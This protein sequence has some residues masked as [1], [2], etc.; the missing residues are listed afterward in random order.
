METLDE[1]STT[2]KPEVSPR[3]F[4]LKLPNPWL[5]MLIVFVALALLLV[6]FELTIDDLK[7]SELSDVGVLFVAALALTLAGWRFGLEDKQASA[8]LLLAEAAERQG[9]AVR[10]QVEAAQ[11]HAKAA[12][13][14]A[15]AAKG[16]ADTAKEQAAAT[17]RHVAAA[18]KTAKATRKRARINDRALLLD[19][20]HRA[21]RMLDSEAQAVRI[22]GVSLLDR[23][24]RDQPKEYHVDVITL[25]ASFVRHPRADPLGDAGRHHGRLRADVQTAVK[26][27][28]ARDKTRRELERG[29]EFELDLREAD[30]RDADLRKANLQAV[31][32]EGA[33]LAGA[34][35]KDAKVAGA[36]FAGASG[37]VRNLTQ[38]QLD[39]CW[40]GAEASEPD[41]LDQFPDLEWRVDTEI[42]Q[43]TAA[44]HRS[45]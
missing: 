37:K 32:L 9:E 11:A 12:K 15:L 26:A 5:S 21:A 17:E 22:G 13:E 45:A 30:L 35:L 20:Y 10:K 19:R 7:P 43:E 1:T 29:R 31:R 16:Q 6:A 24:A 2:T 25:L 4:R 14:L 3:G 18:A 23:L 36:A 42:D 41:G 27:I 38:D 28:G 33:D 8:A 34:L 44:P 39:S 40:K